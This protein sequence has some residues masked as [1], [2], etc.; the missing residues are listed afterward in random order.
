L[1]CS[2][3]QFIKAAQ[4]E[5]LPITAGYPYPLYKQPAFQNA[6][7]Y[8]YSR[9]CCPVAEDLC[10]NSGTWIP[11]NILLGKEKDM[12]DIVKI[13]KKVQANA[14]KLNDLEA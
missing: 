9:T 3:E 11:H 6:T 13:I 5:G 12:E 4:A 8:D 1:G 10:H 2:R 7:F 14:H